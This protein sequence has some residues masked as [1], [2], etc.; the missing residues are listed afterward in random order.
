[1]QPQS[2]ELSFQAPAEAT[3]SLES[4]TLRLRSTSN[5]SK[6]SMAPQLR[7]AGREGR[8]ALVFCVSTVSADASAVLS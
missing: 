8:W 1:M 4:R 2:S 5:F 3:T 6:Y 7:R